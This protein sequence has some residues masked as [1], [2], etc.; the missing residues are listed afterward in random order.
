MKQVKRFLRAIKKPFAINVCAQPWLKA[1]LAI[2]DFLWHT[3]F[4]ARTAELIVELIRP[5]VVSVHK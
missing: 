4:L 2:A 3:A 5:Q 1:G